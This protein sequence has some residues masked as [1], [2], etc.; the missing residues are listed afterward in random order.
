MYLCHLYVPVLFLH[1]LRSL[2]PVLPLRVCFSIL[3]SAACINTV[4]LWFSFTNLSCP[5]YF[6]FHIAVYTNHFPFFQLINI[7]I[8][9][10]TQSSSPKDLQVPP[11]PPYSVSWVPMTNSLISQDM[12]AISD[13]LIIMGSYVPR[14]NLHHSAS[15]NIDIFISYHLSRYTFRLTTREAR[16]VY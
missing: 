8:L 13:L 16:V 10:L 6:P 11:S 15:N 14:E 3:Q 7:F 1:F 12:L 5:T 9:P 4:P 2:N